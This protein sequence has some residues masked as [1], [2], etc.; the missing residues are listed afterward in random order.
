[1]YYT[2]AKHQYYKDGVPRDRETYFSK[3]RGMTCPQCGAEAGFSTLNE[4]GNWD[5]MG[6]RNPY[7]CAACEHSWLDE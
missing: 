4:F 5:E 6:Y 3:L 1:M 2:D 7:R